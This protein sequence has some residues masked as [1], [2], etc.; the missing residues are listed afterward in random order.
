MD[1]QTAL[2]HLLLRKIAVSRGRSEVVLI[3]LKRERS[4]SLRVIPL[5]VSVTS[6]FFFFSIFSVASPTNL[7]FPLLEGG[8]P[9]TYTKNLK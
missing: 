4:Y 5:P 3:D 9:P 8:S 1:G 2:C 7:H 6:S